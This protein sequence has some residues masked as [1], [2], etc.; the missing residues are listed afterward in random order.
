MENF[1]KRLALSLFF[2]ERP[3]NQLRGE[4]R[5]RRPGLKATPAVALRASLILFDRLRRF[6][7]RGQSGFCA[8]GVQGLR[9]RQSD[10]RRA[11]WG[12]CLEPRK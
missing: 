2:E 9:G 7:D 4:P 8:F 1:S 5:E 3:G 12:S 11:L 10:F 6:L